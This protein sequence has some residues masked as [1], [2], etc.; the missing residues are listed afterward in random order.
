MSHKKFGPDRFS[1]FEVYWIQTDRRT[2]K[3]NLY[4]DDGEH[5]I[6]LKYE[7]FRF[8]WAFVTDKNV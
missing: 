3:P 6:S 7:N 8:S 4:I 5:M 2:D 1:R